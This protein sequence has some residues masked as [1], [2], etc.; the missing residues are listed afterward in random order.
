MDAKTEEDEEGEGEEEEETVV[1][2]VVVRS[3]N[4]A[5]ATH[6]PILS[7]AFQCILKYK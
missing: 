5:M 4:T 7:L 6:S 2:K 1:V 3:N